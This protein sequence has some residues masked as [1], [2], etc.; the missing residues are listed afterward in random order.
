MGFIDLFIKPESGNP[1]ATKA[2]GRQTTNTPTAA[3]TR[4]SKPT[5]KEHEATEPTMASTPITYSSDTTS[6]ISIDVQKK[7]WKTLQDRNI[8]G[9]DLMEVLAS[10][11]PI[12]SLGLPIEKKYEL[13]FNIVKSNNPNFNKKTLLNSIDVYIS[14]VNEELA[15]GKRQFKEK[16][17][18]EVDNKNQEVTNL[19]NN[20]TL[21]LAQIEELKKRCDDLSE[22]IITLS[23]TVGKS[24]KEISHNEQ[25]FENT[26]KALIEKLET[27]KQIMS[28][29]NI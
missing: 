3:P 15:S 11:A 4:A 13:A 26:V 25:I 8:P 20:R 6:E 9:P 7:L 14:Y 10:A 27:D 23:E 16:R 21:L 29:L 24:D 1:R 18:I 28:N 17:R 22:K 19:T 2:E 5:V 12:E